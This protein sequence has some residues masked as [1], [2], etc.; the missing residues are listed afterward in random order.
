MEYG[1]DDYRRYAEEREQLEEADRTRI[2]TKYSSRRRK[3]K[4]SKKREP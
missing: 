3:R 4:W 1:A 2:K